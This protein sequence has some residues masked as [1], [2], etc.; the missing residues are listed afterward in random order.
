MAKPLT[1]AE[2]AAI[3]AALEAGD[4]VNAVA[5]H[6]GRSLGTVSNIANAAGI[7]LEHSMPQKSAAA[8]DAVAQVRKDFDL[9]ARLDLLN[10]GFV[11]AGNL[12]AS[13]SDPADLQR[14]STA[15][16]ILIDKRRLEDGDVTSRTEVQTDG[17]ANASAVEAAE[18]AYLTL[19][20]EPVD[21]VG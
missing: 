9:A 4:S 2:R 17:T 10:Q 8:R 18:R 21:L 1:D 13:L 11:K 5:R 12:L 6:S 3:V 15:V 14:W 19:V 16:G 7:E 20:R